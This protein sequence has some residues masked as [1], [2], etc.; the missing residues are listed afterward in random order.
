MEERKK[1]I[2]HALIKDYVATAEPVGSRTLAKK[3]DLG[4]SPATIRNEMTDLEEQGYVVQP[5][6]S[7]GRVPSD[8]GYR[9]YV[10]QLMAEDM[11]A[12]TQ[13]NEKSINEVL[14]HT[15]QE[16]D[17]LMKQS[18]KL[19][20]Q[21]TNYTAIVVRPNI[22]KGNLEQINLIP[23]GERELMVLMRSDSGML[24]HRVVELP[25]PIPADKLIAFERLLNQKFAG[26]NIA[27]ITS[28][29][30]SDMAM[31]MLWHTSLLR[32]TLE[33]F[34][35][36]FQTY[37]REDSVFIN[38][39]L[40]MLNQPE[41][42]DVDKMRSVL[43]A[44]ETKDLMKN[45]IQPTEQN[46]TKIYIG[47]ELAHPDIKYCSVVTAPYTI[48]GRYAGTI[49]VLGPTRMDYPRIVAFVE[50]ISRQLSE[51]MKK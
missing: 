28:T 34:E 49:G 50:A 10:D 18:A 41:F 46:S 48:N 19:L 26:Y 27:D 20:S 9:Y 42:R 1:K 8:K 15:A 2:L 5:F 37:D 45:M 31:Q 32:Q 35:Q 47:D 14:S 12:K 38:G 3:Y 44:L 6:T 22:S 51:R 21:L 40:N 30:I 16:M 11:P 4:V 36:A 23:V 25:E 17:A 24:F 39:T 7:A 13:I 43:E 33:L 29:I